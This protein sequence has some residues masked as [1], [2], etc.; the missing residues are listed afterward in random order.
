MKILILSTSPRK[1]FSTSLYLGKILKFFL[2][3]NSVEIF[4]L[5][6]VGDYTKIIGKLSDIDALVF[7]TP[8]YVDS[9]PSTTL[10]HL[11]KLE[12]FIGGKNYNFKVYSILNCGFYEGHQCCNALKT[13]ELWCK[14]AG[15]DFGGGIGVQELLKG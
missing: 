8:V 15:L 11:K 4:Q 6:S 14:K 1:S 3:G 9:I 12:E 10:E 7:T 2:A 5:K 13:Y